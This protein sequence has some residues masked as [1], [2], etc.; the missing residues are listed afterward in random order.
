MTFLIFLVL[1]IPLLIPSPS[2]AEEVS[3]V[4]LR[5]A[6]TIGRETGGWRMESA[7][8]VADVIRNR[9]V[10]Q[11]RKSSRISWSDIL[12]HSYNY[13]NPN[14]DSFSGSR[15]EF[16]NLTAEQLQAYGLRKWGQKH[17]A[18]CLQAASEALSGS[19]NN[20]AKGTDSFNTSHAIDK[21]V[22][23]DKFPNGSSHRFY[24]SG[25]LGSF[26]AAKNYRHWSD[27]GPTAETGDYSGA[28]GGG[29]DGA[30]GGT[31]AGGAGDGTSVGGAS[32]GSGGGASGGSG[33]G[34]SRSAASRKK[35]RGAENAGLCALDAM[36][37]LYLDTSKEESKAC[38]YCNVVV[39]LANAYLKAAAGALPSSITLGE[40]ILKFGFAIWL[41]YYILQQVSSFTPIQ[42]SKVLQEI[43]VMGFKVALAYLGVKY[44]ES[45]I[46]EF[47]VNPIG[48]L[49]TDYGGA[50]FDKLMANAG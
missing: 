38:W 6:A 33:G 16:A 7:R 50:M 19:L 46:I 8:L 35:P 18:I 23:V 29:Y 3:F 34:G 22:I 10:D 42:P 37:E 1:T 28:A 49:G 13:N 41:A 40:L 2:S 11:K 43:L 4:Q 44:A 47:Y 36:T 15:S 9:Y 45:A 31:S 30:G 21:S 5:I 20:I 14:S 26:T 39:V 27:E 25:G 32:G 48:Q 24:H 17:W 12:Y